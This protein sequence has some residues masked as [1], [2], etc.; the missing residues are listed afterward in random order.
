MDVHNYNQV[1]NS[2]QKKILREYGKVKVLEIVP[3]KAETDQ[4]GNEKFHMAT[5]KDAQV[6]RIYG[7]LCLK[8][9]R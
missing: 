3:R 2:T 8:S 5:R 1:E 4:D 7:R 6:E 9:E